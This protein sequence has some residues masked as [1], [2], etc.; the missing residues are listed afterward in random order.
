ML[1]EKWLADSSGSINASLD[2]SQQDLGLKHSHGFLTI[3]SPGSSNTLFSL[4]AQGFDL[5]LIFSS[6]PPSSNDTSSTLQSRLSS[7]SLDLVPCLGLDIKGWRVKPMTPVSSFTEGVVIRD[8]DPS[9]RLI[10]IEVNTSSFCLAGELIRREISPADAPSPS[11][12][13]FQLRR[14]IPLRVLII[15]APIQLV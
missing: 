8:F 11:G 12:S 14:D 2:F 13:L 4:H 15:N 3:P 9:K 6:P 7:L 1:A 10:S 5:G